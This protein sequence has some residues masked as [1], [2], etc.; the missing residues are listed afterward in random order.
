MNVDGVKM[1]TQY[2]QADALPGGAEASPAEGSIARDNAKNCRYAQG[3]YNPTVSLL[4]SIDKM[5]SQY[6]KIKKE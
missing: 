4:F 3:V 5:S 2:L 6:T 1:C